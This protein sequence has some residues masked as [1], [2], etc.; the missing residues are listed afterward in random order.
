MFTAAAPYCSDN[1][2]FPCSTYTRNVHEQLLATSMCMLCHYAERPLLFRIVAESHLLHYVF[3]HTQDI[4]IVLRLCD[5]SGNTRQ[6]R[7]RYVLN[8]SGDSTPFSRSRCVG[9]RFIR[10]DRTSLSFQSAH[11]SSLSHKR[12]FVILPPQPGHVFLCTGCIAFRRLSPNLFRTAITHIQHLPD[13]ID[14][15]RPIEE[16]ELLLF[17]FIKMYMVIPGIDR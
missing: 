7:L 8:H 5:S 6:S 12:P 2:R 3:D 16:L 14:V 11:P 1:V 17:V 9:N 15:I 4:S 13:R 10:R